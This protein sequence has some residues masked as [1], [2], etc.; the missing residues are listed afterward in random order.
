MKPAPND[1]T[2]AATTMTAIQLPVPKSGFTFG[3]FGAIGGDILLGD[4]RSQRRV[5]DRAHHAFIVS[6]AGA[7]QF[8]RWGRANWTIQTDRP[9]VR[10][11]RRLDWA[12]SCSAFMLPPCT[13]S[14]NTRVETS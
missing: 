6:Q 12:I 3:E 10:Q 4:G 14:R 8:A 9:V 7:P 13:R 2:T 1:T 5:V 11:C